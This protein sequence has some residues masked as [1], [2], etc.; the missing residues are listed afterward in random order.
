[1]LRTT[2][3]I[4]L[5][6]ITALAWGQTDRIPPNAFYSKALADGDVSEY[7]M[8]RPLLA[9]ISIIMA[10]SFPKEDGAILTINPDIPIPKVLPKFDEEVFFIYSDSLLFF[11]SPLGDVRYFEV[12]VLGSVTDEAGASYTEMEVLQNID[13]LTPFN[14]KLKERLAF[15]LMSTEFTPTKLLIDVR[16][17]NSGEFFVYLSKANKPD[18]RIGPLQAY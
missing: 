5:I 3:V 6:S 15:I 9:N 7:G 1:M 18:I 11:R 12:S 16:E 17:F 13:N 4:W 8:S 10:K 14:E 2:L